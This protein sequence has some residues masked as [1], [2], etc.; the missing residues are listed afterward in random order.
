MNEKRL[1]LVFI[2]FSRLCRAEPI[3]GLRHLLRVHGELRNQR[4]V[5]I[6]F[7]HERRIVMVAVSW[8]KN[9]IRRKK[10]AAVRSVSIRRCDVLVFLPG[11]IGAFA[12]LI[13][14]IVVR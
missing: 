11:L 13:I 14:L 9:H 3:C 4:S 7:L 2:F 5:Q 12:L 1:G 10:P 8:N 6:L